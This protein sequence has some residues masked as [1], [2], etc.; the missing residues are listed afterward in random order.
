MHEKSLRDYVYVCPR[1]FKPVKECTCS[2][3]PEKL[4]QLV[5][6]IWPTVRILNEKWYLTEMCCEG[7]ID[8]G[9]RIFVL[10]YEKYRFSAPIP[11]GFESGGD[12]LCASITGASE[13]A[14]QRKKRDLLNALYNW[15][16][17]LENLCSETNF[18]GLKGV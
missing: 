15:A 5:R 8:R 13:Q 7:H 9:D 17:A 6:K 4:V 10:F 2:E 1:C 18:L 3:Y 11:K 16:C 14:K 12:Y